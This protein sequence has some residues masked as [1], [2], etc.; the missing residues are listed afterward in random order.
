MKI[1][2]IIVINI[3]TKMIIN[4]YSYV[5]MASF[6]FF[7]EV[8]RPYPEVVAEYQSYYSRNFG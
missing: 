5:K 4:A 6:K 7:L 3:V 2:I 8:Y 1:V